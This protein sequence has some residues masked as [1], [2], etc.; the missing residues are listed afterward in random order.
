MGMYPI[1]PFLPRNFTQADMDRIKNN[2]RQEYQPQQL[3]PQP[4]PTGM[5]PKQQTNIP[6]DVE[7]AID[8]I[9]KNLN[10][11]DINFNF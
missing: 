4:K 8:L 3:S 1:R 11:P 9:N 6:E 5:N 2:S 10:N 7:G